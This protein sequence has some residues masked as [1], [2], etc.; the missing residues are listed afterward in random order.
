MFCCAMRN[1]PVARPAGHLRLG[2]AMLPIR[3]RRSGNRF[4]GGAKRTVAFGCSRKTV[5][6]VVETLRKN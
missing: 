1:V 3:A 6:G 5:S 2:S 4:S